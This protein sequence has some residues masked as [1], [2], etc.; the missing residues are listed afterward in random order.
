MQLEFLDISDIHYETPYEGYDVG[1]EILN[2][3]MK[4]TKLSI[5][6]V[7][8]RYDFDFDIHKYN[9]PAF[10]CYRNE[11]TCKF[12]SDL[13]KRPCPDDCHCALRRQE[14]I[15][16]IDCRIS[17]KLT[18][19][20]ELPI[21]I[22]GSTSL[23]FSN[24]N[25]TIL[26]NL[27]LYGYCGVR[28]L[29]LSNNKL[30]NLTVDQLPHNLTYLDLSRNHFKTL[31][32]TVVQ[33]LQNG[34][35]D[36]WIKL[37]ENPWICNCENYYLV[38]FVSNYSH[39]EDRENINCSDPK[40]GAMARVTQNVLCGSSSDS[41]FIYLIL[42]YAV[43][44]VIT[45][46]LFRYK[47]FILMWL[48]EKGIEVHPEPEDDLKFDAF[49]AY[50]SN[51][52]NLINNYVEK[53]ENGDR[54]YK[55]CIYH[56]DFPIGQYISECILKAI[57]DSRRIIILLTKDFIESPW[58]RFEFHTAMQAVS[59]HKRK[60]L[61][62]IKYPDADISRLDSQLQFFMKLNIYLPQ[63]HPHFWRKLMFSMP[64][65][66]ARSDVETPL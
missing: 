65:R 37:S 50:S 8:K 53:L 27:T 11:E 63:D 48:Y 43:I 29:H 2:N 45:I 35:R 14:M 40:L 55:L 12:I 33:Y 49:I 25:L 57:A 19:I 60:R 32:K 66:A 26:P 41:I 4:Y 42:F 46:I 56:R 17:K 1:K 44:L 7:F 21:P 61:I 64:H 22:I 16:E 34:S 24:K 62:V 54:K 6:E 9:L 5:I 20:P 13:N 30:S 52:M 28:E 15:F 23:N 58:G 39:I 38:E 59:K 47:N 36:L 31:N 10:I 51:D 18:E 3:L